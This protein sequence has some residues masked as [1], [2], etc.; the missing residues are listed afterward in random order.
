MKLIRRSL[1]VIA[2]MLFLAAG[3]LVAALETRVGGETTV[4]VLGQM[5]SA[6]NRRVSLSGF[7]GR[8]R[9]SFRIGRVTIADDAGQWVEMTSLRVDWSPA[10]LLRGQARIHQL[11]AGHIKISRPER[12]VSEPGWPDPADFMLP[13]DLT[14]ARLDLALIEFGP[15]FTGRTARMSAHGSLKADLEGE[16]VSRLTVASLESPEDRIVVAATYRRRDDFLDLSARLT[17]TRESI[18]GVL[19]GLDRLGSPD[20]RLAGAGQLADWRGHLTGH[21]NGA[22]LIEA[23]IAIAR[24]ADISLTARGT[25][26]AEQMMPP[27]LRASF[28]DPLD[29]SLTGTWLPARDRARLDT[30]TLTLPKIRLAASGGFDFATSEIRGEAQLASDDVSELTFWP[31]ALAGRSVSL[32]ALVGGRLTAP[33]VTLTATL[34]EPAATGLTADALDVS[35]DLQPRGGGEAAFSGEVR[36]RGLAGPDNPWPTL[37]GP[38]PRLDFNGQADWRERRL[39]LERLH[40]SAGGEAVGD[41]ALHQQGDGA[42]GRLRM[43]VS[44]HAM[45]TGALGRILGPDIEA[46]ATFRF[47]PA[48]ELV[49]DKLTLDARHVRLGANGRWHDDFGKIE[50]RYTIS[51]PDLAPLSEAV[52]IALRGQ[53]TGEG[54]IAGDLDGPGADLVLELGELS[55]GPED[56]G[57]TRISL[58]TPALTREM[59]GRVSVTSVLRGATVTGGATLARADSAVRL[60]DARIVMPGATLSGDAAV[61]PD[62]RPVAVNLHADATDLSSLARWLDLPDISGAARASL[63]LDGDNGDNGEEA[64]LQVSSDGLRAG[65][66]GWLD[67]VTLAGTVRARRPFDQG[68]FEVTLGGRPALETRIS[69]A[70]GYSRRAAGIAL[71]I[72]RLS[73][74]LGGEIIETRAPFVLA[75]EEGTARMTPLEADLGDGRIS[76]TARLGPGTLSLDATAERLPLAA[77]TRFRP[78]IGVVGAADL[79]LSLAGTPDEP[80][81]TLEVTAPALSLAGVRGFEGTSFSLESR[82]TL[83]AGRLDMTLAAGQSDTGGEIL[84]AT[85]SLPVSTSLQ[86]W[87]VT[88]ERDTAIR[89]NAR[90]DLP[91]ELAGRVMALDLHRLA[92]RLAGE[93]SLSGTLDDPEITG[94][95]VSTDAQYEYLA[96]GTLVTGIETEIVFQE[97][98][99]RISGTARD[100]NAGR[101]TIG[102]RLEFDRAPRAA[103]EFSFTDATLVRQDLLTATADGSVRVSGRLDALAIS[104]EIRT[105]E[106]EARLVSD[107]PA[108]IIRLNVVEIGGGAGVGAE[109][110]PAPSGPA[111]QTAELV[112]ISSLDLTLDVPNRL[113]VRGRGLDSEWGGR[114]YIAGTPG[115]PE[116]RGQLEIIRGRFTFAGKVFQIGQGTISLAT[117]DEE[118]MPSLDV[119]AIYAEGDF[120]ATI[121]ITGEADNPQFDI[122]AQPVMPRDEIFSQILFGRGTARLTPIEMA[123]VAEAALLLSGK[124]AGTG[125][126]LGRIRDALN[127]DVLSVGAGG[128][129]GGP[130]VKAGKYIS[131]GVYLGVDQ[132]ASPNSTAATIEVEITPNITVESETTGSGRSG[133]GVEWEFDY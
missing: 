96:S 4:S 48:R 29:F 126:F 132:G 111:P 115:E 78:A 91:L 121:G 20:L 114:I 63:T 50:A 53:V 82:G 30:L 56:I 15:A 99:A 113:F 8:L 100:G 32:T 95:L 51:L 47:D 62:G 93:A 72:D 127:V 65:G 123:Q 109:D 117:R 77:I 21:L 81:G 122:S 3:T 104:G 14:L 42:S 36:L 107:L 23:E 89:G 125:D 119:E 131:D 19:T 68:S 31:A 52:G 130:S 5:L 69:V 17:W 6:P 12:T 116:F 87:N 49:F 92:G 76:I 70:G 66:A 101:L 102:G 28:A 133:V 1:I 57:E 80:T 105:Q 39:V 33:R 27:L 97:D 55:I 59:A 88:I 67:P 103:L 79:S 34:A 71:E 98:T 44:N 84:T 128:N 41:G 13:V 7:E 129:G 38:A 118:I 108:D 75:L 16:I 86:P 73:G 74:R 25:L 40:L 94:R 61:S 37:A 35:L 110:A 9:D 83:R 10:S 64:R 11:S 43:T 22:S 90:I 45:G 54:S 120:R 106:V 124:T 24:A 46:E 2:G 60:T 18:F 26:H 85:A 58:Q 112:A